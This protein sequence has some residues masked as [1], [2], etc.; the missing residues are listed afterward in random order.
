MEKTRAIILRKIKYSDSSL[1]IDC[2]TE[3]FGRLSCIVSGVKGG[4]SKM[5]A[6]FFQPG[7]MV[8]LVIYLKRSRELQR[9]KEVSPYYIYDSLPYDVVKSAAGQFVVELITHALTEPEQNDQLYQ[10]IENALLYIDQTREQLKNFPIHFIWNLTF[11]LGCEPNQLSDEL[12]FFDM[13]EGTFA[14]KGAGTD[15]TLEGAAC[16]SLVALLNTA[17]EQIHLLP[18]NRSIRME[19]M[20]A[21]QLYY[22]L[23][24]EKFKT[25]KSPEIFHMI[26]HPPKDD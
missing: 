20:N 19:L 5:K 17:R 26:F 25:L 13:R 4:K 15:Y 21:A 22:Q 9:I 7:Q 24:I 23:H 12:P 16:K 14:N 10:Y 2:L 6:G 18:I 1:I 11:F 3:N 8:E